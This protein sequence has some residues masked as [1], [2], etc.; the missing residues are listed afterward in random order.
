MLYQLLIPF[1]DSFILFNLLRYI[2]FRSIAAFVT[3]FIIGVIVAPWFIKKLHH[4]KFGQPIR[5]DGP[6]SHQEKSG[7]PTMGGIFVLLASFIA[8][9]LWSRFNFYVMV[10]ALAMILFGGIGFADDWLKVKQKK[11][12]G[13][14]AKLKLILQLL[15]SGIIITLLYFNPK[16][17][18]EREVFLVIKDRNESILQSYEYP[19]HGTNSFEWNATTEDGEY[20]QAGRYELA[21]LYQDDYGKEVFNTLASLRIPASMVNPTNGHLYKMTFESKEIKT[22]NADRTASEFIIQ[23]WHL[24]ISEGTNRSVRDIRGEFKVPVKTNIYFSFYI[25]YYS[26]PLFI[27]PAIIGILFFLFV[28]VAFTNATNLADGLDGLASGMGIILYIPFAIIAYVMGN[29]ITSSYLRF[30][31]L[32]GVGEL[33]VLM[34][35]IIGGFAAFLWYNTKPAQI[36]MGDVG[37]L[38]MGGTIATIAI[39]VKQELLLAIAGGMFVLETVS[40]ALQV[41]WF[42]R[43]GKR[44]FKMAPLHHHF[45]LSGWKETQVVTRF[46]ILSALFALLA[47]SALKI[48]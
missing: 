7:T 31:F 26:K 34:A 2:T 44:I 16:N 25:P 42:K 21:S 19:L 18:E 13:I 32:S 38:A 1:K 28:L 15:A 10:V 39:I 22:T 17:F 46:W 24:T 43:T 20:V 37:S 23:S 47:L 36:F 30:P 9:L 6:Q 11:S 33:T 35:A 41:F 48:R 12:D 14:N 40:V 5:S 8:I 3:A 27:W 45:E 4:L 29:V